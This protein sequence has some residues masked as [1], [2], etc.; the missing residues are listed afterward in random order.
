MAR[1]DDTCC[2]TERFRQAYSA[3]R[4]PALREVVREVLGTDFGVAG[5]T[6][7]AE[8]D[9]LG[10]LL[11]LGPGKR[12]LDVGSGR[13]WPGLYLAR[14]TGCEVV[15]ADVP[16]EGLGT[17]MRRA[18]REGLAGR[19]CFVAASGDALPLRSASFDAVVHT[20]VLCCLAPK[21]AVLRA[22]RRALRSGG[23][24]AFSVI[25]P[26]PGLSPGE[27]RRVRQAGPPAVA[28]RT[29]YQSMLRSAGFVGIDEHDLT[30]TW[31]AT[32]RRAQRVWDERAAELIA[33]LGAEEFDDSQ[34]KRSRS[35]AATE[36]G[37]LR[38]AIFVA[39]RAPDSTRSAGRRAASS[40]AAAGRGTPRERVPFTVVTSGNGP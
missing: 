30:A 39:R 38:R 5:T 24:T 9:R 3:P 20:E 22:T 14:E 4:N 33:G 32:A 2:T 27:R 15:S 36:A 11:D 35:I 8:A 23:V 13:G 16:F 7:R 29:S 6:T 21:L 37:L 25:F 28:V 34:T 10:R 40:T 31:L 17:G 12:L 1:R 19:A 18:G 26:V